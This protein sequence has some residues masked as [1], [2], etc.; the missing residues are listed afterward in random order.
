MTQALSTLIV[1]VMMITENS[2]MPDDIGD[3]DWGDSLKPD[4]KRSPQQPKDE[5]VIVHDDMQ[6]FQILEEFIAI[7][8]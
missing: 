8:G 5:I 6:G 7:D 3:A 2:I 4:L 1:I